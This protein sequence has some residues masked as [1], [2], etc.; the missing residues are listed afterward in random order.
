MAKPDYPREILPQPDWK[1]TL[2]VGDILK[3]CPEAMLGHL[4]IGDVETL[5]DTSAGEGMESLKRT[6]IPLKRMANFS[7]NLL[8]AQFVLSFFHFLPANAGAESWIKGMLVNDDLITE[9]NYNHYSDITIVAW[10]MQNVEKYQIPYP[11]NFLKQ[12]EFVDFQNA[13]ANE[14]HEKNAEIIIRE[15]DELT[16]NDR[17]RVC[18]F[19]GEARCN[20]APVLLNYWHFTIDLYSADNSRK[21]LIKISKGWSESMASNLQDY[22]CR[23]FI[24]LTDDSQVPIIHEELN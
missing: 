19:N 5:F 23:T 14:A 13:V 6:A 21:P 17:L 2:I 10:H 3:C 15:W 22:L 18:F 11:R 20:H 4:L 1:Q 9:N 7:C 24:K 12:K 8:G 16:E